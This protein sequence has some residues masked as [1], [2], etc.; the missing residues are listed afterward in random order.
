MTERPA[1]QASILDGT[2]ADDG[3]SHE[4]FR[5][6]Q[7]RRRRDIQRDAR[8]IAALIARFG[9]EGALLDIGF[10]VGIGL[11]CLARGYPGEVTG[12]DV[13][14][15]M[16]AFAEQEAASLDNLKT[17][18]ADIQQP[19]PFSEGSFGVVHS[20]YTWHHLARPDD[21]AREVHRVLRPGG[22]FVLG[23]IDPTNTMTRVFRFGYGILR[24]LRLG[25][26]IGEAAYRS[27]LAAPRFERP[28]T[29]LREAGFVV[30]YAERRRIRRTV[31]ARKAAS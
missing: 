13:D 8:R 10:G 15:Q 17:F 11:A 28:L 9:G 23:D 24:R 31:V 18:A 29:M 14:P 7:Q 12:V 30:E 22:L 26:P 20:L 21:A 4:Q 5:W 27:I 25:W 16:V 1:K 2:I 19:L 3:I 6:A